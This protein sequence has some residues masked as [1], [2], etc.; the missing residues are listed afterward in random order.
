MPRLIES[1]GTF[2]NVQALHVWERED[3]GG[4]MVGVPSYDR[5]RNGAFVAFSHRDAQEVMALAGKLVAWAVANGAH[6][7]ASLISACASTL[8]ECIPEH[9]PGGG[10]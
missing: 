8:V 3:H 6:P 4:L 9:A 1:F 10:E 7:P 5:E 2:G